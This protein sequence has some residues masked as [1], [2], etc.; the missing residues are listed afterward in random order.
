MQYIVP[1]P[2]Q[3][4]QQHN[5][6]GHHGGGGR[7]NLASASSSVLEA[8]ERKQRVKKYSIL[9]SRPGL[10]KQFERF[11]R[12]GEPRASGDYITLSQTEKWF[13][14]SGVIDSWNVTTTDVATYFRKISK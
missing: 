8:E 11:A 12:Y 9:L 4:P 7:H 14:Q 3:H 1:G 13:K 5:V 6:Q 10:R 2:S